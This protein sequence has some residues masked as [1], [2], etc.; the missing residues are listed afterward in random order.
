MVVMI[1]ITIITIMIDDNNDDD[2]KDNNN[3]NDQCFSCGQ[4]SQYQS[5]VAKFVKDFSKIVMKILK[6]AQMP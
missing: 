2:N 3:N 6:L 5:L 1:M 4:L